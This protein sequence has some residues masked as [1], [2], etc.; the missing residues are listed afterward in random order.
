M[1]LILL[2]R[3][4]YITKDNQIIFY[5]L[6]HAETLK[7]NSCSVVAFFQFNNIFKKMGS[8]LLEITNLKY[9]IMRSGSDFVCTLFEILETL[10][11]YNSLLYSD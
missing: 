10:K 5:L 4:C 9:V 2:Q 1:N 7:S 3:L 11:L 6:N 8:R